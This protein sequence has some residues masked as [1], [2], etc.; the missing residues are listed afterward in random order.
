MDG[1]NGFGGV[2]QAVQ[3]DLIATKMF[4][5]GIGYNGFGGLSAPW[6]GGSSGTTDTK[7]TTNNTKQ[8]EN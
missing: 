1:S 7:T 8:K 3:Q 5:V 4:W 2:F 6:I